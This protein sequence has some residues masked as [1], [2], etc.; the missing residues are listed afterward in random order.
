MIITK[1]L[2]NWYHLN[3][4]PLPWRG[5]K[6]PYFIWLSEIILQQTQIK[7]G[8]PYF[9]KFINTFPTLYDLAKAK[10]ETVL[11]LWEGLGYYSRAR[12]LLETAQHITTNLNGN[13]PTTYKDLKKLKGI[14]DYTASAIASICFNEA[15]IC[16]DGNIYRFISRLLNITTPIQTPIANKEFKI[17]ISAFFDPKNPGD[18]NQAMMEFGS[19]VCKPSNPNCTN[20]ELQKHCQGFKQNTTEQLPVKKS[21]KQS[22]NRFLNYF[23]ISNKN[24]IALNQQN[25]KGIWKNLY[26]FPF[27]ES[28]HPINNEI[29]LLTLFKEQF[30]LPLEYNISSRLNEINFPIKTHKLSH[31]NL[32]LKFWHI[33]YNN[34][35]K[36]LNFKPLNEIE[37]LPLPIIIRKALNYFI[38]KY[39]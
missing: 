4:R 10:E 9:F 30:K 1:T 8:I 13:F 26:Q 29:E 6:N 37:T 23:I 39:N 18:F 3:K 38:N 16:I 32:N 7:Q 24:Q 12:N 20:C 5:S 27:V 31:Q 35:F 36:T 33:N 17:K 15:V 19:M 34:I 25:K 2:L 14:G 21:K 28:K 22:I 11:K